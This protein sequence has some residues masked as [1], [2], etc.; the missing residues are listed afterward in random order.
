VYFDFLNV[1]GLNNP[2][3]LATSVVP[4]FRRLR[5]VFLNNILD[6]ETSTDGLNI[7]SAW[8]RVL[9]LSFFGIVFDNYRQI[10]VHRLII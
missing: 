5:K 7:H 3:R 4:R 1:H 10:I 6:L 2:G 9:Y 8:G